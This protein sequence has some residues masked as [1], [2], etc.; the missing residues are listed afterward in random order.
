LQEGGN[1]SKTSEDTKIKLSK[2]LKGREILW[3][4]KVMEG[5]KKLWEDKEY[6]E[7]QTKQR[8]KKRGKYRENIIKPL[9]IDLS[10]EE[11][12]KL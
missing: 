8:Y 2:T 10:I 6:R 11:M 5:V 9:R 7:K 4:D 1:C 3:R 12:N